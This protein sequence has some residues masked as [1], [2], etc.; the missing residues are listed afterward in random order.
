VV[1]LACVQ[2]A[3]TRREA[4]E[5]ASA[6]AAVAVDMVGTVVQSAIDEKQRE[7]E[8]KSSASSADWAPRDSDACPNP[9][10][11]IDTGVS[12]GELR[13]LAAD[14]L[15][16]ERMKRGQGSLTLDRRL[17]EDAQSSS[18]W[19][20]RDSAGD[21]PSYRYDVQDRCLSAR[22][23]RRPARIEILFDPYAYGDTSMDIET[24]VVEALT[25]MIRE[26]PGN[27]CRDNL[28][29]WRWQHV[30][31]GLSNPDGRLFLTLEFSE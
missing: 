4:I 2:V 29:S 8:Q 31:I 3:C 12:L 26:A 27:G 21:R 5:V 17:T 11:Y 6:A 23:D 22:D 24:K 9:D 1:V 25:K 30:G 18:R 20:A 7:D 10:C 13:S 28:L 15:D 16:Q 14:L 19:S